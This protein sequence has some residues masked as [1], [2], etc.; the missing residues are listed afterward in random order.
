MDITGV[1][2]LLMINDRN[3]HE[4]QQFWDKL[5]L[6]SPSFLMT[7]QWSPS[8]SSTI[9]HCWLNSWDRLGEMV[10]WKWLANLI[11]YS[12]HDWLAIHY[13]CIPTWRII[14]I[15]WL[16]EIHAWKSHQNFKKCIKGISWS[17]V[18]SWFLPLLT[19]LRESESQQMAMWILH[20]I[21]MGQ[22]ARLLALGHL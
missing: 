22:F 15:Y 1:Y 14:P 9:G 2:C 21:G 19:W 4:K 7:S 10:G 5:P 8:N 11:L 16:V 12:L 18:F 17:G 13:P 3:S 6:H 20:G